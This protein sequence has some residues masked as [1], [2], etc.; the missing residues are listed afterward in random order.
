MRPDTASLHLGVQATRPTAGDALNH[1]NA[2]ATSLI[3]ALR[4]AGV[5]DDD[6]STSG[7]SIFPQYGSENN[8]ITG[9]QASNNITVTI[10]NIT[11][12][13]SVIDA[14]AAAAGDAITIGGVSFF[15]DDTEALIGAARA[16]AIGNARKR[17]GEF[18]AAAGVSVGAVQ[19]ISEVSIDS[20]G[21][22]RF[23]TSLANF[24]G[25][26]SPTPTESGTQDLSV[27]ITV[28]YE[29]Q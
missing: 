4:D 29:L 2:S 22:P 28:V 14:A 11:D 25:G 26:G 24:S 5:A 23:R 16:D 20:P 21:Q 8:A 15:V 17:A 12:V 10:R 19:E 1:T 13:G 9:Y 6:I 18:A 27:S 3:A 7:L